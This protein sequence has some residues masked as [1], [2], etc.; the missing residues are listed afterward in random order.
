MSYNVERIRKEFPSL[1]VEDSGRV[2]T[3]LDNPAGT[4]VTQRVI[5]NTHN[6]FMSMNANSGG[7]FRTSL[8]TSRLSDEA[9]QATAELLNANSPREIVFGPNM[10]TLTLSL[11]RSLGKWLKKGDEIVLSRMDHDA[12]VNPW[13]LL[14]EDL[15]LKVKWLPFN[16]DTYRFDLDKLTELLDGPVKLV[17]ATYASNALGTINDVTEI[18]TMAREAG[19]LSFIDA[20]QYVPHGPTDVQAIGCDFLACSVYKFFGGH[21]GILWGKEALLEKLP[22]YKVRPA[23]DATPY[24][25]ETGTPSYEGQAG[26]LGAI[27]YLAW[28]GE[29]YGNG[30]KADLSHFTGRQQNIH[31]GMMAMRSYEKELS[32]HLIAGLTNIPGV[33]IH[34]VTDPAEF[35]WRVPTIAFTREGFT[36]Q[37]IA[38][39]LAEENIFVWDGDYYAV[40]VVNA[41]G[42]SESGGMV[43]VGPVHYNTT[44]ELDRL[45]NVLTEM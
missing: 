18:A 5:D 33:K 32:A 45:L 26:T 28:V 1:A 40:E 13:L 19:A 3:Y 44:A 43:R 6:Y 22:A 4:Q 30:F 37:Q 35:D 34:G 21:Q 41:L 29:M 24:K 25:F 9:R 20:V 2:R 27:E 10:T 23:K 42:L 16:L 12:N 39:R 31:A 7:Y 38:K 15:G 14:A 36:P 8:E 11:S 17:A